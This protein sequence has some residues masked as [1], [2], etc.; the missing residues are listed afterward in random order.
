MIWDLSFPVLDRSK[1][2]PSKAGRKFWQIVEE[3]PIA[4]IIVRTSRRDIK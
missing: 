1:F 3:V 4:G 2:I